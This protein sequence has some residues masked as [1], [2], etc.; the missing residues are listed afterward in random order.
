MFSRT[1]IWCSIVAMLVGQTERRVGA[2]DD[3]FPK[4]L[5]WQGYLAFAGSK[6]DLQFTIERVANADEPRAEFKTVADFSSADDFI[7]KMAPRLRWL[8]LTPDEKHKRVIHVIDKRFLAVKNYPLEKVVDVDFAG[9]PADLS[10]YLS[11]QVPNIGPKTSGDSRQMFDDRFTEV[12][13]AAKAQ[14]ARR[15]LTDAVPLNYYR[16]ILW[17]A[18]TDIAEDSTMVQFY[19]SKMLRPDRLPWWSWLKDASESL[20]CSF[21]V[22]TL[23]RAPDD[24]LSGAPYFGREEKFEDVD[25]LI[26][27]LTK[28][29]PHVTAIKDS[30]R[31]DIVHIIDK[32]LLKL[33]DY[34]LDQKLTI[35]FRGSPLELA[36]SLK[37]KGIKAGPKI[38][39]AT[40]KATGGIDT[41][42]FLNVHAKDD[43]VR[44]ILTDGFPKT[45]ENHGVLWH[46]RTWV[47][48][49]GPHTSIEFRQR[50]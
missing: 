26:R 20:G 47:K 49:D 50:R 35:D 34:A 22:E 33:R 23:Y 9:T 19:G 46:A 11:R 1:L 48:A 41:E 43:Q 28:R 12:A 40:L 37:E 15:V 30:K 4:S 16:P 44:M 32:E 24:P 10:Q 17:R 31:P 13:I 7:K 27:E 29:V 45:K 3:D 36:T 6:C 42:T 18:E 38:S 21:T 2:A 5:D 14:S 39:E 8:S 25:S